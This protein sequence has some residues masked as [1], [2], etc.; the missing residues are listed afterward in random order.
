MS[1]DEMQKIPGATIKGLM[2][3]EPGSLVYLPIGEVMVPGLKGLGKED[4]DDVHVVFTLSSLPHE[5]SSPQLIHPDVS[6]RFLDLG[7]KWRVQ[8]P[9]E[10]SNMNFRAFDT[11]DDSCGIVVH[12][13]TWFLR[14]LFYRSAPRPAFMDL[15][16]GRVE[17]SLPEGKTVFF[18]GW[19][20]ALEGCDDFFLQWPE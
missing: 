7:R 11:G 1:K 14:V 19:K 15:S 20:F 16:T 18:G 4:G 5:P 2:A 13:N 10:T 12:A 17:F 3:V 8:L 6:Q 9:L